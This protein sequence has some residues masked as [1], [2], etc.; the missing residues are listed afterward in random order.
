MK[1]RL[2]EEVRDKVSRQLEQWEARELRQRIAAAKE[3][4]RDRAEELSREAS[5]ELDELRGTL[6]ATLDFDDRV[7]W[8]ALLERREFGSLPGELPSIAIHSSDLVIAVS[9]SG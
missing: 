4:L 9:R 3:D 5:A 8:E 1:G 6:A 2:P 7:D